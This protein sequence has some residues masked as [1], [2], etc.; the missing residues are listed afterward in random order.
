MKISPNMMLQVSGQDQGARTGAI[1]EFMDGKTG[2]GKEFFSALEP[3]EKRFE[4]SSRDKGG[5][6]G[7][8]EPLARLESLIAKVAEMKLADADTQ[9]ASGAGHEKMAELLDQAKLSMPSAM[10][11]MGEDL[12]P[13]AEMLGEGSV[14]EPDGLDA[15]VLKLLSLGKEHLAAVQE[16]S[17]VDR[18]PIGVD[19][20]GPQESTMKEGKS[21]AEPEL[22][23]ESMKLDVA[24]R[25][26]ALTQALKA[27]QQTVQTPVV[28]AAGSEQKSAAAEMMDLV[29]RVDKQIDKVTSAL[30]T[31]VGNTVA[32]QIVARAEAGSLKNGGLA[33]ATVDKKTPSARVARSTKGDPTNLQAFE[34]KYMPVDRAVAAE[35]VGADATNVGIRDQHSSRVEGASGP[36]DTVVALQANGASSQNAVQNPTTGSAQPASMA[37]EIS[38]Q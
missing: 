7:F 15:V 37:K 30:Q 11:D 22:T 38:A 2:K 34:T 24:N 5:E 4:Q 21:N 16:T 19:V 8:K 3:A 18:L 6:G 31:A 12:V 17:D 28:A 10:S 32:A 29:A 33:E 36:R 1:S 20:L 14:T 25:I 35:R 23:S 13:T 9:K 27:Q 26:E